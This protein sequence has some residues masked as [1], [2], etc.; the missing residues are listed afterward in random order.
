MVRLPHD[1]QET[2]VKDFEQAYRGTRV[3]LTG[4]TGFTGSWLA[5]WLRAI[6]ADVRGF[7]LD[8]CTTPNL[9]EAL[10]N[11]LE[12]GERGDI[13]DIERVRAEVEAFRPDIVL[14][15]AAQPLVRRSYRDPLETFATNVMGTANVLEAARNCDSVRSF[16]CVTTDKVYAD[17]GDGRPYGED[18]HLGGADPYSASKAAAEI[19]TGAYRKTMAALG[20]GM[21]VATVRGGNIIGGGDWSED[22]LIP[23]FMRAWNSGETLVI[24]SPDAVRPWQHV[25]S[26][27]HGYLA[28]GAH[29]LRQGDPDGGSWNIGPQDEAALTV[30]QVL[31]G[32]AER[33]GG[34]S[35]RYEPS[36]LKETSLLRLDAS[37]VKAE[38]GV[39]IPWPTEE[40]IRRTADWYR[41]FKDSPADTRAI[42]EAQIADY[43]AAT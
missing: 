29:L 5:A 21:R 9:F 42:T 39:S 16:V 33:C 23:D 22:R 14:H 35:I 11:R 40:V 17:A 38:L 31:D 13:R 8:P 2:G 28:V 34:V 37:K 25:L 3:F 27:C 15:L 43:R 10:G 1:L 32:L 36:H 7:S 6:G 26:A 19:V 24:R 12:A 30:R 41:A 4:H 20:N 18:A